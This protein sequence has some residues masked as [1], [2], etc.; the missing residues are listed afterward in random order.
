MKRFVFI[1]I[2]LSIFTGVNAQ[3]VKRGYDQGWKIELSKEVRESGDPF[4]QRG[5][6]LYLLFDSTDTLQFRY[7]TDVHWFLRSLTEEEKKGL[8]SGENTILLVVRTR[9]SSRNKKRITLSSRDLQGKILTSRRELMDFYER[10][11]PRCLARYR[12]TQK[13]RYLIAPGA[14]NL[15]IYFRQVYM[16]IPLEKDK[17]LMYEVSS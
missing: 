3:T 1:I 16:I 14:W 11:F 4:Y 9:F 2:I 7:K 8:N 5:D 15:R 12:K 6:T 17:Y 13:S 10:E